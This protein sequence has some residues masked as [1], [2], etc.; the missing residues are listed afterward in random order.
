[1]KPLRL[2]ALIGSLA[3]ALAGVAC[4]GG[5]GVTTAAA[6]PMQDHWDAGNALQ[7]AMARGDLTGA[8]EAATRI[9]EVDAI[10]GLTWD[11]GPYLREMRRN[12]ERVR[13]ATS[14]H[15]AAE[16]TGSMGAACGQCHARAEVGPHPE[17]TTT[18]PS[19][20]H[21]TRGHMIQ[22]AW[23]MDRMWEGLVV[24]STDRWRAGARLLSEQP[25]S[26]HGVSTELALISARVHELGRQAMEDGTPVERA[27]RFGQLLT[28]C[29]RCH[30]EL[31]VW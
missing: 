31:G 13:D 3:P 12:A 28:D 9:A 22:H 29:A 15:Q 17:G 25:V 8:R 14:F 27:T 2:V 30:V 21:D 20:E 4:G 7:H 19:A 6:L 1:M 26:A 18:A 23:A 24:P 16:A 11:A 10:P 5:T